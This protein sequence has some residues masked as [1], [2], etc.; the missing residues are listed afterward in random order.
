[1]VRLRFDEQ[2]GYI[3]QVRVFG[4]L[5]KVFFVALGS[6]VL[7][8][9]GLLSDSESE[10]WAE[11]V[12]EN[13][14]Q[15]PSCGSIFGGSV[16]DVFEGNK[17]GV[18]RVVGVAGTQEEDRSEDEPASPQPQPVLSGTG[19]F[20]SDRAHVVTAASIVASARVLWVE[21]RG[22]SYA[23]E[24]VGYDAATN[25]AVIRL[26][27]PPEL[28]EI[29]DIWDTD[30]HSLAHIGDFAI[31]I[32]C[33]LDLDPAPALGNI[34]GKNISYGERTFVT[35]YLR[36][37]IEFCGGESGAPVFDLHGKLVGC[38]VAALP[39]LH[40]SFILPKRALKRVYEDIIKLGKVAYGSIG[41]DIHAEY[42]LSMGQQ[43]VIS[44]VMHDSYA[45]KS[46]LLTGDVLI[47]MNDFPVGHREDLHNALFFAR[48][49]SDMRIS[50]MRDGEVHELTMKVD[51][52][53]ARK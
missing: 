22:L 47:S 21:Y 41:I 46:G 6:V 15:C 43:I 19:F 36:S 4:C 11:P 32:G 2:Q 9:G 53:V 29:V 52:S 14:C 10:Q 3:C 7:F 25:I 51:Q 44:R 38:M 8:R 48:P 24:C 18:V 30:E 26:L 34:V 42:K 28:F 33:R 39:E 5:R 49:G 13:I 23:A 40:S 27:Q 45:E 50:V 12:C 35:T 37:D 31:F 1:M 16:V 20:V 17:N